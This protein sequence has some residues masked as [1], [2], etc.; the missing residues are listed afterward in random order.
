MKGSGYSRIGL[1]LDQT[2]VRFVKLKNKKKWEVE[3]KGFLEM[4]QG[5]FQDDQ[6]ADIELLRG[7][8]I[9]WVSENRLKGTTVYLSIPTSQIIIRGMSIQSNNAKELHNL[10]A[11]EV[12]T[13]LHLPFEDPIYD[14]VTTGEE[15]ESTKLLVFAVSRQLVQAYLE[16]LQSAGLKVQGIELAATALAKA[17]KV[18][19]KESFNETMLINLDRKMLEIYMF[20]EGHPVFIRTINLYGQ[21]EEGSNALTQTQLSEVTAEISR[22]L[23]FY[24]FSIHEG[25]T[26]IS[27]TIITGFAEGRNQLLAELPQ[28]LSDMKIN[29]IEFE[30]FAADM[31]SESEMDPYRVAIGLA[32]NDKVNKTIN[33]LNTQD[34]ESKLRPLLLG[35]AVIIWVIGVIGIGFLFLDNRSTEADNKQEIQRLNDQIL[36]LENKLIAQNGST[37]QQSNPLEAIKGIQDNRRD[38]LAVLAELTDKMPSGGVIRTLSYNNP[39]ELG[40]TVQFRN[41]NDASR[42]L[43][44]LRR[45]SFA[46]VAQLQSVSKEMVGDSSSVTS[47]S[48]TA[49]LLVQV[50]SATYSVQFK[51]PEGGESDGSQ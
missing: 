51:K 36:L 11:L 45:M 46:A 42:Y 7:P 9:Q 17:I 34:H 27:Q 14:Y 26:R 30:S 19:H 28:S 49:S 38:A 24:Q 47:V 35:I 31:D 41:A 20:H 39:N 40:M 4:P 2:G 10:V 3:R 23:N 33:L 1:T 48:G 16:L 6:L 18:H 29:I 37:V 32:L 43:F 21:D 12:E 50:N 44:D 8:L 25:R 22:M 15:E 13:T 5:V